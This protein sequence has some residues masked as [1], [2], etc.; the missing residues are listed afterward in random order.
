MA[1]QKKATWKGVEP[2]NRKAIK[3]WLKTN[4]SRK[5]RIAQK[6]ERME[7]MKRINAERFKK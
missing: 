4:S 6:K 3:T 2:K 1:R 7:E 5:D